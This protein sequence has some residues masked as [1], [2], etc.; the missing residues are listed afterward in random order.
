MPGPEVAR[1]QSRF[2]VFH[3]QRPAG[4]TQ[5]SFLGVA[6]GVREGANGSLDRLTAQMPLH[7]LQAKISE[8]RGLR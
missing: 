6:Q 4:L 2:H 7:I 8:N 1:L 3:W 5:Q